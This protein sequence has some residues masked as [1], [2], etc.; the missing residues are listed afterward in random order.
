M[1]YD[2]CS[3]VL[4]GNW[5]LCSQYVLVRVTGVFSC[6]TRY[7]GILQIKQGQNK[8]QIV[9]TYQHRTSTYIAFQPAL[10]DSMLG[11]MQAPL[12][13]KHYKSFRYHPLFQDINH[14][15]VHL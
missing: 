7:Q 14:H 6:Q 4:K 8:L 3:E 9:E 12:L 2:D 11:A 10:I 15:I 5:Y 13:M 1:H